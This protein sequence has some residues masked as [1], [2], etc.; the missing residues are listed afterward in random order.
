[1]QEDNEKQ[2]GL[3]AATDGSAAGGSV[4][5]PAE[6]QSSINRQKDNEMQRGLAASN[7]VDLAR[8]AGCRTAKDECKRKAL[9]GDIEDSSFDAVRNRGGGDSMA[10]VGGALDG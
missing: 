5:T 6:R 4:Q 7:A 1:M 3:P 9:D 2:A 10:A 8:E